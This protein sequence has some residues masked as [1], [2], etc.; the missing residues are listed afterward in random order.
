MS[1]T[2]V[3][4]LARI[5]TCSDSSA[6]TSIPFYCHW[7]DPEDSVAR[8]R[9]LRGRLFAML[10][11][12]RLV[13]SLAISMSVQDQAHAHCVHD[14]YITD[15]RNGGTLSLAAAAFGSLG[16]PAGTAGGPPD[17]RRCTLES[18]AS[19]ASALFCF[20]GAGMSDLIK[21]SD[22]TVGKRKREFS[23]HLSVTACQVTVQVERF[24]QHS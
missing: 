17:A 23:S 18:G 3:T 12:W 5:S 4:P 21:R 7:Q 19:T 15:G 1:I 13:D 10:P 20:M 22:R 24:C 11:R 14:E 16:A 9:M 6:I 2:T 8:S